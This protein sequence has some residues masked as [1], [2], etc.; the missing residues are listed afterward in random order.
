MLHD[1]DR[2]RLSFSAN[3]LTGAIGDSITVLPLVVALAVVTEVSLPHVLLAFG[4]FQVVWG[5]VYGLPV[6]VEPMKALAALGVAGTLSYAELA[7]SGLVLGVVL[8]VIGGSGTLAAVERWIGEPVVRGVQLAVGLILFETAIGLAV[9]DPAV[10]GAGLGIAVVAV[11]VGYGN[12]SALA[13]LLA[14]VGAAVWAAGVPTPTLPGAPPLPAL[15]TGATREAAEGMI[16]QL[17]MTVG[18]AALATSLL[19]A[20]RFDAEVPPDDLST[21]MGV[22]NLLAVPIGGIPMCHGC[23]G[24]AG[25]HAFGARTGGANVIL[26]IGYLLAAPF[27]AASL[28]AA[29]PLALLGTLLAVVS[30]SLA[31][32]VRQSSNLALSVGIGLAA[33]V[34]NLGVAFLV[35]V[36]VH[37]VIER[38]GDVGG[39]DGGDG[40]GNDGDDG[41]GND[42][43][44]GDDHV[45]DGN[46]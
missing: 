44:D 16:A 38:V 26:G 17:A 41:H 39:D 32:S 15:A 8:L 1:R 30:V 21:S 14:G 25:K 13:V 31:G 37:L 20:D 2:H 22:M 36:L 11:A 43:D 46:A 40:H 18:N 3:E 34:V 28:L 35:G 27:A 7:L 6:S 33:L 9:A 19:F 12:A 29:F 4:V 42:G 45:D 10:A 24:V 5:V 23:D